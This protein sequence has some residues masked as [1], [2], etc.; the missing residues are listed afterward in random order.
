MDP[1]WGLL[2]KEATLMDSRQ[3]DRRGSPRSITLG[4]AAL[5]ANEGRFLIPFLYLGSL[6]AIAAILVLAVKPFTTNA[7]AA[8][9]PSD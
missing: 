3:A 9:S 1:A 7:R 8:A 6:S 5:D 4:I 2:R